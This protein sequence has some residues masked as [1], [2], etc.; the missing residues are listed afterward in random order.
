M[1]AFTVIM[2]PTRVDVPGIPGPP[3]GPVAG[4][5]QCRD[6]RSWCPAVPG[7]GIPSRV[8][9]RP[10]S[11]PG[12]RLSLPVSDLADSQSDTGR[13]RWPWHAGVGLGWL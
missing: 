3:G 13:G 11:R 8:P 1:I 7:P 5:S 2:D 9:A 6:S 12:L 4:P 10:D